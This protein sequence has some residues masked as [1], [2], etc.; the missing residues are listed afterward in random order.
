MFVLHIVFEI[1]N[2]NE[3]CSVMPRTSQN[4]IWDPRTDGVPLR[5]RLFG[6]PGLWFTSKEALDDFKYWVDL[7]SANISV[8]KIYPQE[9]AHFVLLGDGERREVQNSLKNAKLF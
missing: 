7:V 5:H 2:F 6:L 3:A 9:L 8:S 1:V 4:A